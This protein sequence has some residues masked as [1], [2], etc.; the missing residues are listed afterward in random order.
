MVCG[1]GGG[2][3]EV[4]CMRVPKEAEGFSLK[5]KKRKNTI[6][7][8]KEKWEGKGEGKRKGKKETFCFASKRWHMYIKYKS[9]QKTALKSTYNHHTNMIIIVTIRKKII[10]RV[11]IIINRIAVS[12][13]GG[14][15][16][17]KGGK[18]E[19]EKGKGLTITY[20]ITEN[21][22]TVYF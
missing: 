17:G 21:S 1:S 10:M 8:K 19:R 20:S 15:K 5:K 16:G 14:R 12:K 3:P 13:R 9:S 2:L 7:R 11:I 4:F 6:M 22:K 18:K